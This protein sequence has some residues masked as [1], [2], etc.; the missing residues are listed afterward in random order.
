M[1]ENRKRKEQADAMYKK[2][3]K[4]PYESARLD[5]V[6][7]EGGSFVYYYKQKLPATENTKKI[8][9]TLDGLIL[10]KDETRTELPPSDTLTY[11]VSSMVQFLDRTPRYRKRIITRKDEV[12]LRAYVAYRSG[13]VEF[14]ESLGSNRQEIDKV[15]ETI[16]GINFTGE[17]L[18]DSIR[19]TA[20]SSP[21]GNAAMNLSLSRERALALKDTSPH[22]R[23]TVKGWTRFSVR[24]GGART[25]AGCM[26]SYRMTTAWHTG[27]SCCAS[28]GRREIRMSGNT[29]CADMPPITG[30]S[31]R[32][33]IRFCAVWSSDSTYTAGAWSGI[34]L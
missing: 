1:A 32:N 8:D 7:K 15:F 28:C 9:L 23:T 30:A 4:F 34:R 22:V 19:M 33:T 13:S 11:F 6:I 31:G 20:T 18:I 12:S 26:S 5:T 24:A 2:Y 25:G 27:T 10:S 29:S 14:S 3:V 21:E 16:R 17:F